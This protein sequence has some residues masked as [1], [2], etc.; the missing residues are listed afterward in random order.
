MNHQEL[1]FSVQN[2]KKELDNAIYDNKRLM[3]MVR[4]NHDKINE[5]Y[6]RFETLKDIAEK[7][8]DP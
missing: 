4:K 3:Q 8:V 2:L 1:Y 7:Y 6:A 5:L